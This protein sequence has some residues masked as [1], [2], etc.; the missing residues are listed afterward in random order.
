MFTNL[1]VRKFRGL[2]DLK[3][4]KLG[5]INLVTGH[6]NSGKT[7]LLEALF[8][9][10]GGGNP[11]LLFN[12]SAMRGIQPV[13]G[14][15]EVI[16]EVF[17]KPLFSGL[18]MARGIEISGSHAF[19]GP[20]KLEIAQVLPERIELPLDAPDLTSLGRT[21]S[22]HE[23]EFSFATGSA[24]QNK[25]RIRAS[26]QALQIDS[27]DKAPPFV[28]NLLS[29]RV[30]NAGED[31]VRLGQLRK[32]KQGHLVVDALRVFEP[33]L[34]SIE[35]NSAG[36]SPMIWGDIGLSELVPLAVMG[37]GMMRIAR[38]VLAISAAPK[39]LVL[40]DEIENGLHHSILGKVWST[41]ERA[42]KQFDTQ[43]VA[44][45]HSFECV[46]AAHHSLDSGGFRLHRLE[47]VDK[48][49]VCRSYRPEQAES[50]FRHGLE[51]R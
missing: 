23:L 15:T 35:D 4:D 27:S 33:K 48:K 32:R 28:A 24:P 36:G 34:R 18:D 42:A 45:T 2:S 12:V 13:A 41:V 50:A 51:V 22:K 46:E 26:G 17:W 3:I 5:R 44:T 21:H 7:T 16:E 39:G 30:G 20:L 9:L 49:I 6:N 25:S 11:H 14:P 40:V 37:E 10:S 8:L 19:F 1:Q 31:V 43:I 29:S 47:S 38:L